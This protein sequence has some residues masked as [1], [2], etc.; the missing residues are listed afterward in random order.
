MERRETDERRVSLSLFFFLAPSIAL[1]FISIHVRGA[2][3]LGGNSP[4]GTLDF[5]ALLNILKKI[6][7]LESPL[8]RMSCC[9]C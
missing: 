2:S 8:H 3:C 6:Q 4:S 5:E 7:S 9:I 1:L